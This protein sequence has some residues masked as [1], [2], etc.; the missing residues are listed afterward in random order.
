MEYDRRVKPRWQ[1]QATKALPRVHPSEHPG[2]IVS[3]MTPNYLCSPKALRNLASSLGA[4]AHFR[5]LV[6][7]RRPMD[8]INA[9][10]KMF[11]QW[12]WVRSSDLEAD[13]TRQLA[14]LRAC[15]RTLYD[16]PAALGGLSH[17]EVLGYFGRCWRGAWKD[18][19]TNSMPYVCL[20]SWMAVG[21]AAEQFMLVRQERL[22]R[23][24]A[25]DLL[26]AVSNFTGLHYNREVLH[27]KEIELAVHC[28]APPSTKKAAAQQ[29][30]HGHHQESKPHQRRQ[31]RRRRAAQIG[32]AAHAR[33]RHSPRRG[34]TDRDRP[35]WPRQHARRL[36]WPRAI[37]ARR[38]PRRCR[39]R[40]LADAH[41]GLLDGLGIAALRLP[42][43]P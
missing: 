14:E 28:E 33:G 25:S 16:D 30:H 17:R 19:V 13:V 18:F 1:F 34:E 24:R 21:F 23:A 40:R 41:S 15:N 37:A 26:G 10:Y 22:K 12:G 3:D 7:H 4:P 31:Q 39:L 6:L 42:T 8:M 43:D 36:R 38:S 20:R 9:S 11:I 5:M 29:H 35:T 27:D 32:V 2:A